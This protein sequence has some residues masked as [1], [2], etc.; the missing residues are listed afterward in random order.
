MSKDKTL[1]EKLAEAGV[2]PA[3]AEHL[4]D[5]MSE[6]DGVSRIVIGLGGKGESFVHTQNLGDDG[7]AGSIKDMLDRWKTKVEPE[8]LLEG[9]PVPF[10]SDHSKVNQLVPVFSVLDGRYLLQL[11]VDESHSETVYSASNV[12]DVYRRWRVACKARVLTDRF[13]EQIESYPDE[14]EIDP[15]VAKVKISRGLGV[16]VETVEEIFTVTPLEVAKIAVDHYLSSRLNLQFLLEE[17]ERF[18]FDALRYIGSQDVPSAEE[19]AAFQSDVA[20][21]A[22]TAHLELHYSGSDEDSVKQGTELL[23]KMFMQIYDMRQHV[24]RPD[25]EYTMHGLL[26][27]DMYT[28]VVEHP[29]G[30]ELALWRCAATVASIIGNK[31]AHE[32]RKDFV[33]SLKKSDED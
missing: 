1:Q 20:D 7:F 25:W 18:S 28:T 23:S 19:R 26:G 14:M 9:E 27:T 24:G 5:D 3:V 22:V 12:F 15:E 6:N 16:P 30:K 21:P 8:V 11:R 33:D 13:A 4:L 2:P 17:Q 29:L 10:K 31:S 32:V